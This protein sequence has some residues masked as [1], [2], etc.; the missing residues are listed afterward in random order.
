MN[1]SYDKHPNNYPNEKENTEI[2]LCVFKS[3]YHLID[4]ILFIN[5]RYN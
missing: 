1:C 3:K 4:T 5:M 2:N